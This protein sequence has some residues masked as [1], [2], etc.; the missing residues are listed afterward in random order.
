MR[1][2]Y[3]NV[4]LLAIAIILGVGLLLIPILTGESAFGDVGGFSGGHSFSGG[5]HS[6]SGSSSS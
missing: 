4:V 2:K 5:G 3:L 6:S 1:N